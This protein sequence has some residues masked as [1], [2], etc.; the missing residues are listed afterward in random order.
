MIIMIS[1]GGKVNRGW[2]E[3]RTASAVLMVLL[4]TAYKTLAVSLHSSKWKA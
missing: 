1:K 2:Q 4:L 3:P